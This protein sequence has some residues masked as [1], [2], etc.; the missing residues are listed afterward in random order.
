MLNTCVFIFVLSHFLHLCQCG[1]FSVLHVLQI[2]EAWL[3][4]QFL[5]YAPNNPCCPVSVAHALHFHLALV[6]FVHSIFFLSLQRWQHLPLKMPAKHAVHALHFRQLQNMFGN[7]GLLLHVVLLSAH[8]WQMRPSLM[9][10]VLVHMLHGMHFVQ[11][12]PG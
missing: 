12:H 6:R 11:A 10:L 4:E 2:H 5:Q 7:L 9:P 8:P 3:S 1:S